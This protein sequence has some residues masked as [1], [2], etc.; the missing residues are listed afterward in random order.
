MTKKRKK[1]KKDREKERW[2]ERKQ[3]KKEGM[4]KDEISHYPIIH[5]I[6][7]CPSI[8]LSILKKRERE[9]A[10][11]TS[12]MSTIGKCNPRA[13]NGGITEIV[14]IEPDRNMDK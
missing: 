5:Q 6:S 4:K 10:Q 13:C 11:R 1:N 3:G 14:K 12:G 7:H 8:P 9:T 2:G